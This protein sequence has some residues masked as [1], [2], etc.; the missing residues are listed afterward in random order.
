MLAGKT[1]EVA[2][3]LRKAMRE[4][5]GAEH[6]NEHFADTRDTLCYATSENQRAVLEL[7][8]SGGDVALV[9][10]GYNSSNTS[11]LV[12]LFEEQLPT[13]FV[14]D[15]AEIISADLIRH[16]ERS[17]NQII[18]SRNWLPSSDEAVEI[19]VGA[20]ASC[21]DV[22]VEQVLVKVAG[23]FGLEEYFPQALVKLEKC[24][25]GTP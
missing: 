17:S 4:R 6:L 21:P 8:A 12:E 15:A 5:Y 2:E 10:G 11:H 19:L 16:L 18:T 13:F 7:V 24:L 23:F 20:G 22:L 3:V 1:R 14:R 25:S 9:I